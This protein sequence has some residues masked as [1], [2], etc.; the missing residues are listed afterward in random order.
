MIGKD[1]V[2]HLQQ[3]VGTELLLDL[4]G[5]QFQCLVFGNDRHRG[6]SPVHVDRTTPTSWHSIFHWFNDLIR[7]PRRWSRF[8]V[9]RRCTWSLTRTAFSGR[10]A[11]EA[12]CRR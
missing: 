6:T 8:P 5:Q 2:V 9:P 10:A 11:H 3:L 1:F 12:A 4:V 7:L